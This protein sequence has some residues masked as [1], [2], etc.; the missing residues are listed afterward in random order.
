ML[1]LKRR[2]LYE[3]QVHVVLLLCLT[4][5]VQL[6]LM[7]MSHDKDEHGSLARAKSEHQQTRTTKQII[8]SYAIVH[9]VPKTRDHVFDD[10]LNHIEGQKIAHFYFCNNF[11]QTTLYF[12]N[13]WRTDTEVN[14]Q[15]NCNKI[16]HLS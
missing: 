6:C 8:H 2:F 13:F 1:E 5:N 4:Q 16:A 3:S 9:C 12:D 11:Y 10:K 15:Q 14:L 7:Q